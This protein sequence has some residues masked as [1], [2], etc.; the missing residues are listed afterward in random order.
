[1]TKKI[2][3]TWD[4]CNIRGIWYDGENVYSHPSGKHLEPCENKHKHGSDNLCCYM[5][6]T[7]IKLEELK[8]ITMYKALVFALVNEFEEEI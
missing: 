4:Y 2:R 3:I 8:A 6:E 5:T 1:M 7:V